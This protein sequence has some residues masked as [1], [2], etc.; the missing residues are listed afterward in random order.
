MKKG[1]T[2]ER[3]F[4]KQIEANIFGPQIRTVKKNNLKNRMQIS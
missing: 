3:L 1:E 2:T 4:Q